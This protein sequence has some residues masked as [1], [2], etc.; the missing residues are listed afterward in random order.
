[1]GHVKILSQS[2]TAVGWVLGHGDISGNWNADELSR[3]ET[4]LSTQKTN[5]RCRFTYAKTDFDQ[6]S[7]LLMAESDHV[8]CYQKTMGKI[9][10]EKI[11]KS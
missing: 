2:H 11:K 4:L 8:Q 5:T 3:E 10:H 9:G 1:M 7:K 6:K